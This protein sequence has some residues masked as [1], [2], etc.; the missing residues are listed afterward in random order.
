VTGLRVAT[1]VGFE[2][3]LHD[4]SISF[5]GLDV[6]DLFFGLEESLRIIFLQGRAHVCVC[7]GFEEDVCEAFCGRVGGDV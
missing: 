4:C 7:A 6:L 1:I 3:I 2:E 5:S